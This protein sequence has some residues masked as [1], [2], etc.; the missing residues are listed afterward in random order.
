[1]N[2]Y[3]KSCWYCKSK[4]IVA[5]KKVNNYII[6]YCKRC[7][8]LS[9]TEITDTDINQ[10]NEEWYSGDYIQNYL[11]RSIGL[12][13]RFADRIQEIE[14]IKKGGKILDL[15]SGVGLFLETVYEKAVYKWSL[16]GVEI[17][18][19]L[20][21]MAQKRLKFKNAKLNLGPIS[22]IQDQK[23]SFDCIT[24]F[25][26]LEHDNDLESTLKI[27]YKLLKPSGLLVIQ[28]PNQRS[29]MA[30][31]C[32]EFWDWWAVPDHIFHFNPNFLS[33]ILKKEG[34][35][36]TKLFTW[37][38]REEF[39]SN[40]QGSLKKRL[41]FNNA[42][43]RIIS[44]SLYIPLFLLWRLLSLF[45]KRINIGSLLVVYAKKI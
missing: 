35:Q 22:L 14:S 32:G 6:S 9:T 34:Y 37:D 8:L 13:K 5:Y 26:V 42:A 29:L 24:C 30:Y 28:S 23:Q 45:E 36:I 40:I 3:R 1:M 38:P 27:M 33:R 19:R 43:G 20:F 17:N 11:N 39:I 25:D 16:Y 21:L 10:V 12:K 7:D 31:L 4:E 15:G 41:G 18:R 2:E 44:K